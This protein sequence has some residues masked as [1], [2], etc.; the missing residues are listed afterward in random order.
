MDYQP[1]SLAMLVLRCVHCVGLNRSSAT[2]QSL[3][4]PLGQDRIGERSLQAKVGAVCHPRSPHVLP[5]NRECGFCGNRSSIV[6]CATSRG[7]LIGDRKG[8]ASRFNA[9]P[10][11]CMRSGASA[12]REKTFGGQVKCRSF[13]SLSISSLKTSP[14]SELE[15]LRPRCPLQLVFLHFPRLSDLFFFC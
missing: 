7:D 9:S 6:A 10:S 3:R 12:F 15:G 2:S 1:C 5:D 11:C 13:V 8:N 14:A 4:D